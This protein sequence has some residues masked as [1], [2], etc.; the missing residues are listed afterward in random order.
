MILTNN[1]K[2]LIILLF[3]RLLFGGYI[4]G[5]DQYRLNDFDSAITVLMIYLLMS[6][7]ASLYLSGRR[8]GLKALI[9]LEAVFLCLNIVFTAISLSQPVDASLHSPMNNLWQTIL[10]YTFSF[11]T[12]LFSIRT[13]RETLYMAV[14]PNSLHSPHHSG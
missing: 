9:G 11:L 12:L 5:M 13:Y 1:S 6:I 2:S 8:F 3:F 4:V 10:R 7:F 14:A